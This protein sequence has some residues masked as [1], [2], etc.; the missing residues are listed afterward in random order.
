MWFSG[1]TSCCGAGGAGGAEVAVLAGGL[2]GSVGGC[3]GAWSR[4]M[5]DWWLIG[6]PHPFACEGDMISGI[7]ASWHAT[8]RRERDQC[9]RSSCSLVRARAAPSIA[10]QQLR[11]RRRGACTAKDAAAGREWRLRGTISG[12]R[13]APCAAMEG[14]ACPAGK[15]SQAAAKQESGVLCA[16]SCGAAA[17][18]GMAF[19]AGGGESGHGPCAAGRAGGGGRLAAR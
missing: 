11:L 17:H 4:P 13:T 7:V 14:T 16:N 12:V 6:G 15:A 5:P 9:I 8:L 10:T 19:G 2:C 1:L 18:A 3:E